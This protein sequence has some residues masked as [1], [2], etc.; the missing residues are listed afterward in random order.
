MRER[1]GVPLWPSLRGGVVV[2]PGARRE[3]SPHAE[4]V[5]APGALLDQVTTRPVSTLP[6]ESL[7]TA[8]SCRVDPMLTLPGDGDTVTDATGTTVTVIDAVPLLPSLVAVI[9]AD[10]TA[11]ADA[12]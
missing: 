7:V 5:P 4:T 2:D 12:R 10:P 11:T 9:V 6:A 8:V 3:T 1:V